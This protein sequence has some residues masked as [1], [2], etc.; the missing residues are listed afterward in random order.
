MVVILVPY[1]PLYEYEG[2][3]GMSVTETLYEVIY[4]RAIIPIRNGT[5]FGPRY[6][7]DLWTF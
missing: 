1:I 6:Q 7:H 5:D 2:F 4:R 3:Y